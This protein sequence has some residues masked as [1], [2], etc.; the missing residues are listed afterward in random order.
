MRGMLQEMAVKVVINLRLELTELTFDTPGEQIT[1]LLILRKRTMRSLIE[2]KSL[3]IPGVGVP[4]II[5]VL[6]V[7]LTIPPVQMICGAE[8]RE[9]SA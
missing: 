1:D 4:T 6:I 5:G 7:N 3:V 9:S 2:Q 8:T